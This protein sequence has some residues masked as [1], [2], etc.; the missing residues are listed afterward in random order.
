MLQSS[1]PLLRF[2]F[3]AILLFGF[4][5]GQAAAAA[6][7]SGCVAAAD[8]WIAEL[9]D[10]RHTDIYQRHARFNCGF[11]GKWV[12]ESVDVTD[13]P[14][15]ERLC[16]DLVLIWTHRKCNYFRDDINPAAYEPC[17]EWSREMFRHCM[18]NDVEWFQVEE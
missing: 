5:S 10:L 6:G 3:L 15:R 12:Q 14:R 16:N 18:E 1:S 4:K 2:L 13:A 11:S 8:S 9:N 17:R 7:D